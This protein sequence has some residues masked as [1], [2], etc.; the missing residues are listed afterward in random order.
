MKKII[1]PLVQCAIAKLKDWE[2]EIKTPDEQQPI[3]LHALSPIEDTDQDGHYSQALH[4]A[5]TNKK[6]KDFKNIALTGVYESGKSSI[7][8]PSG[9]NILITGSISIF[10][11]QPSRKTKRIMI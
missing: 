7:L 1:L 6:G 2:K 4:W 3:N 8:K 10:H 11:W 5:V 9:K